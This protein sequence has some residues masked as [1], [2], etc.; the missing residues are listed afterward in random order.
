MSL[1]V[2]SSQTLVIS[3]P[4]PMVFTAAKVGRLCRLPCGE[5]PVLQFCFPPGHF[6]WRQ[7]PAVHNLS[8]ASAAAFDTLRL[9]PGDWS[10]PCPLTQVSTPGPRTC[11]MSLKL[12]KYLLLSSVLTLPQTGNKQFSKW[13]Q[14]RN[15]TL[16]STVLKVSYYN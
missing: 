8:A 3:S 4:H 16:K 13:H 1:Q 9:T 15:H 7:G 12:S 2:Y 10:K 6:G 14:F 5:A 11:Q